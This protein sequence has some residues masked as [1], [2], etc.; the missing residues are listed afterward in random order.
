MQLLD[1]PTGDYRF[2]TGIAPYSSSVIAQPG[3]VL[4][5]VQ[6]G[7]PLP[8]QAG[9]E[10]IDSYLAAVGRPRQSLCG[11]E[12]RIPQPLSFEGFVAFNRGY[13]DILAEWNILVGDSNPV[14]RTNVA[15][16]LGAPSVPSVYAFT[17][18]APA[19]NGIA[20]PTF[21]VAGAG[22]LY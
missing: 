10:R 20:Q 21:V 7:T 3:F 17:Y 22:D 18:T 5:R 15:P 8:L 11:M 6:F 14:A 2:L 19:P 9:F 12:L 4:H 16:A 1:H 13:R